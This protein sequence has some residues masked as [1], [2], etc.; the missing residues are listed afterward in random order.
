[1]DNKKNIQAI[2]PLSYMQQGL[3]LHHLS[4]E[5]DQ[6]F[7]NME[8]SLKGDLNLDTFKLAY[9][10]IIKRHE[11]IRST[12]HWRDLEK[13]LQVVHKQ[14]D[15]NLSY[16]DWN[17]I[18]EDDKINKWDQLKAENLQ[19]GAQ[20]ESGALLDVTL[21]KFDNNYH[22]LLWPMHHILLDGW[23]GSII[24]KDLIE[25]YNDIFNNEAISLA[26]LPN[27]KAYLNWTKSQSEE[28]P[29]A[30][31]RDQLKGFN[32]SYRFGNSGINKRTSN[33][34]FKSNNFSLTA[35]NTEQVKTYCKTHKITINTFLQGVWSL[36]ISRF[37]D[38][39]D[40]IH[41]TT[42][43]GRSIDFPDIESMAG[44][45]MNVQPIRAQLKESEPIS[46]WF[47]KL[48]KYL[49][50]ARN[51]E[52]VSL[53][54]INE[55]A[56]FTENTSPFDSLVVFENYPSINSQNGAL[57]ISNIKSGITS[58]YPVT[59]VI[60]PD[61]ELKFSIN[62]NSKFVH[63]ES[64][65]WIVESLKK[66]IKNVS[67]ET[68]I[69]YKNLKDN[70]LAYTKPTTDESQNEKSQ[71]ISDHKSPKN[72]V[73]LELLT[74]WKNTLG[75]ENISTNDNFFEIGGKSLIA[76][77]IF[78]LINKKFN[79][80]LSVTKLLEYSTISELSDYILSFSEQSPQKFI[81][82]IQPEGKGHPLFCIHSGGGH[83]F[84][85]NLLAKYL[86][87]ERPIYAIEPYGIYEGEEMHKTI[88]DMTLDY[89]KAI[90]SVQQ[91]GTYN[92]LVYCFSVTVGNEMAIQFSKLGLKTNIIVVDT[93]ASPWTLNRPDRLVARIK[94]FVIRFAKNPFNSIK[95]FFQDRL[96]HIKPML[97][98]YFGK[99]DTKNLEHLQ[100]HL[101]QMCLEYEFKPHS[102][103]ISLILT[104]KP[105]ESLQKVII[106][107][108]KDLTELGEL[109]LFY[110][111][112]NHRTLF[113][114]PDISYL[115]E[116]VDAS[117][118]D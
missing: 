27:H 75:I 26:V 17:E 78:D 48:Q 103:N 38:T 66:I 98:K 64:I 79:T 96:W 16:L 89:V 111:K 3:L 58:T 39:D 88:E 25:A 113:E 23:S 32:T 61:T 100:E 118:V 28:I 93:M 54:K 2:Y 22:K 4:E 85:Y 106:K 53:D 7:L 117:L 50:E 56:E 68:S 82:P 31:W 97:V 1:M 10:A 43:S 71:K 9:E 41:G 76:V 99:E 52:Y 114:E 92:I 102:G 12:V 86:K 63:K 14:K 62:Y 91:E 77:K 46:T 51:F 95:F 87:S 94:S 67:E 55:F 109:K 42:V 60:I 30:F 33:T 69:D 70:V 20:L 15:I 80:K 47:Q 110:T 105:H 108:W 49:F 44:M 59:L 34:D 19:N 24:I 36:V 72:K 40:V 73:E 11:V 18:L 83:V 115:S 6:G 57:Q 107:S 65:D 5:Q 112:G 84:F 13:Q 90:R 81:V 45:F 29:K 74:I 21:I 35:A 104:K 116:Q 101:R 8:C 37:F